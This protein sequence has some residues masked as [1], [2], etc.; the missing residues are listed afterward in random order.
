M[1][2]PNVLENMPLYESQISEVNPNITFI[3]ASDLLEVL[4]M[5]IE[6][7]AAD[8]DDNVSGLVYKLQQGVIVR[9]VYHDDLGKAT[10]GHFVALKING[11]ELSVFDSLGILFTPHHTSIDE[12]SNDLTIFIEYLEKRVFLDGHALTLDIKQKNYQALDSDIST[13]GRWCLF[14]IHLSVNNSEFAK[15]WAELSGYFKHKTTND[16]RIS[17]ITHL[18]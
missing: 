6:N 11:T 17:I 1:E 7:Q 2:D 10:S 16:I 8:D 15:Y 14:F 12:G 18:V 13:C 4:N 3:E 5:A 9:Y